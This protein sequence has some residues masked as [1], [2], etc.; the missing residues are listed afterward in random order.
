VHIPLKWGNLDKWQE[1]ASLC[2]QCRCGIVSSHGR[3][4]I[5]MVSTC[6]SVVAIKVTGSCMLHIA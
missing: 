2:V 4:V 5:A 1:L 6:E 3:L